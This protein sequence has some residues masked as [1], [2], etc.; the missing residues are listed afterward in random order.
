MMDES[1]AKAKGS[2]IEAPPEAPEEP[3]DPNV[4]EKPAPDAIAPEPS[5][6]RSAP[7]GSSA[8]SRW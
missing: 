2:S 1:L 8:C 7:S 4:T 6:P 3:T 5:T